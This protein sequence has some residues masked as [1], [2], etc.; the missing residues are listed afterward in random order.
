MSAFETSWSVPDFPISS[1][2]IEVEGEEGRMRITNDTVELERSSARDGFPAGR[3][4][5]RAA[6][7][8]ARATFDLNG[9]FYDLEDAEFLAWVAGGPPPRIGASLGADVQRTMAALYDSA[10]RGGEWTEVPR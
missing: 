7:L 8:P 2:V 5:R 3:T 6:D 1:T 10:R 4:T 9:E